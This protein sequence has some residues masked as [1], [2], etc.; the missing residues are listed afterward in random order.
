[1]R[2]VVTGAASGIG[3]ATTE[4]LRSEGHQVVGL[5]LHAGEGILAADIRNQDQVD[6]A[7]AAAIESLG[8]LDVLLNNAGIGASC[9]AGARPDARAIATIETNLLG[10]WRVTAA[11]LPSLVESRGRVVNI[12]S[13]FAVVTAPYA[14]AYTASKR[15]LVAYSDV[16]RLEYGDRIGVTTVYPGYVR[17]PIH[18]LLEAEGWF[19]GDFMP[20]D[21]L[22]KAAA[23]VA[24]AC[25]GRY[26]RD[27]ATSRLIAALIFAARHWRKTS[28]RLVSRWIRHVLTKQSGHR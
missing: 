8:G 11:A 18:D 26:R 20:A 27:V 12:A 25:T 28:E 21:P 16:L 13:G 2:I 10:A 5:D 14:A 3:A 17:T 4:R 22:H 23:V 7:V 6:A 24:A 15:A 1:M 9:D 19:M